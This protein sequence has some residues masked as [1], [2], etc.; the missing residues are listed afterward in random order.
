MTTHKIKQWILSEKKMSETQN[1]SINCRFYAETN[2]PHCTEFKNNLNPHQAL[3]HNNF[4]D[5][6]HDQQRR[7]A[8]TSGLMVGCDDS[9]WPAW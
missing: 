4:R 5:D 1:L 7:C 2:R 8:G 3:I 6:D 9:G